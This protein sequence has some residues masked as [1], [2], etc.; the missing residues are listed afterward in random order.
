MFRPRVSA[1]AWQCLLC[2]KLFPRPAEITCLSAFRFSHFTLPFPTLTSTNIQQQLSSRMSH[3]HSNQPMDIGYNLSRAGDPPGKPPG[4]G[5]RRSGGGHYV[6]VSAH[7]SEPVPQLDQ[8]ANS[9]QKNTLTHWPPGLCP[10]CW[11]FGHGYHECDR[12]CRLCASQHHPSHEAGRPC[13]P[14]FCGVCSANWFVKTI[15]KVGGNKFHTLR[16][17]QD[18]LNAHGNDESSLPVPSLWGERALQLPPL[19]PEVESQALR[20]ALQQQRDE[21]QR[22]QSMAPSEAPSQFRPPTPRTTQ[23]AAGR[24]FERMF[25]LANSDEPADAPQHGHAGS[26]SARRNNNYRA[27]PYRSAQ[28]GRARSRGTWS[29]WTR[30][31]SRGRSIRRSPSIDNDGDFY[32]SGGLGPASVPPSPQLPRALMPPST[33][34]AQT[35]SGLPGVS[36]MLPPQVAQLAPEVQTQLNQMVENFLRLHQPSQQQQ[37]QQPRAEA[38]TGTHSAICEGQ[39]ALLPAQAGQQAAGRNPDAQAR[40][41]HA[42]RQAVQETRAQQQPTAAVRQ[43]HHFRQARQEARLSEEQLQQY[44]EEL[45]NAP[46]PPPTDTGSDK[47]QSEADTE[48]ALASR[49]GDATSNIGGDDDGSSTPKRPGPQGSSRITKF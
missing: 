38:S 41:D 46:P 26:T 44:R 30:S 35:G 45:R 4:G 7:I 18:W 39:A 22:S 15:E 47:D 28:R 21:M 6:E 11:Q 16:D 40:V 27:E 43:G 25:V 12:P 23:E 31:P 9:V 48:P 8:C 19:A 14:H 42:F 5:G 20:L 29:P 24:F 49:A 2:C 10:R 33:Q 37:Q 13:T 17:I 34:G 1:A 32:M 36:Q 3:I